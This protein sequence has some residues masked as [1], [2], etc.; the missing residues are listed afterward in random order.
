MSVARTNPELMDKLAGKPSPRDAVKSQTQIVVPY[1][2]T[3]LTETSQ[4]QRAMGLVE[5]MTSIASSLES[6]VIL[7]DVQAVIERALEMLKEA[8]ISQYQPD[9][10]EKHM[11]VFGVKVSAPRDVRY[12]YDHDA[13]IQRLK[14]ALK[15]RQEFLKTL[16]PQGVADP[17]TGEII[18]PAKKV[19]DGLRLTITFGE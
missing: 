19:K 16:P 1:T 17:K 12:D 6:F 10:R 14:A 9:G 15:E 7:R 13:E 4:L 2:L 11:I 18:M 3:A 5:R 8:A